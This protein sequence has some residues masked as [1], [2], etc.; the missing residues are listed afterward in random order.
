M[1]PFDLPPGATERVLF[2]AFTADSV[3]VDS[4]NGDN[5]PYDP[6]TYLANLNFDNVLANAVVADSLG[7]LVMSTL[8]PVTG[9]KVSAQTDSTVTVR[10]QRAAFQNVDGYNIYLSE[11]PPELLPYPGI[12]AP[13]LEPDELVLVALVPPTQLE[14]TFESLDPGSIYFVNVASVADGVVGNTGKTIFIRSGSTV[15]QRPLISAEYLFIQE[16]QS[17]IIEWSAPQGVTV[18]HYH[19]YRGDSAWASTKYYPFYDEGG[20]ADSITPIDSFYIADE[21]ITYYYYAMEPWVEVDALDTSFVDPAPND[22][23]VY[24]VNA[25]DEF[26]FETPFSDQMQVHFVEPRTEDIL[27]VIGR[28]LPVSGVS[29]PDLVA[30]Y[31]SLLFGYD[32]DFYFQ[33]DSI[34]YEHCPDGDPLCFDWHD[35]MRYQ[36]VLIDDGLQRT[37]LEPEYEDPVK[38]Y[39]R[40]LLSGGQLAIFGP[41]QKFLGVSRP[42]APGVYP[43]DHWFVDRFFGIDSMAYMGIGHCAG[44][45]DCHQYTGFQWAESIVGSMPDLAFNPNAPFS[46]FVEMIWPCGQC[47]PDV[48]SFK[49]NATAEVTHTAHTLF[50]TTSLLEAEPI[51]LKTEV[52]G[53]ETWLFGFHLWYMDLAPAR[54]LIEA[55]IQPQVKTTIEPDT[56]YG[57]WAHA[58][59]PQPLSV[60]LGQFPEGLSAADVAPATLIVNSTVTPSNWTIL[61]SHP[62]YVGEVLELEIPVAPFVDSYGPVWGTSARQYQVTGQFLIKCDSLS[63][64]GTVVMSGHLPGDVSADGMLDISDLIYLVDYM[65]RDGAAPRYPPAAD[66]DANCSLDIGDIIYLVDFYFADGAPPRPGCAVE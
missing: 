53:T 31:D 29:L 62:N 43:A 65:F 14:Y 30:F 18:D 63:A 47:A 37:V 15:Y 54:Q 13:W 51:G 57:Y 19:L 11:V 56:V 58:I 8:Y 20:A 3:H 1:G 50:P 23:D 5:L 64:S 6:D 24:F 41:I 4:T 55:I 26:G 17:A 45:I 33:G 44:D 10:W 16:S 61:A 21:G 9:L 49:V 28:Q 25:V 7:Q 34:N 40:Y 60:Y 59:D 2:A 27:V 36:L 32:Y 38:G 39:T 22:N 66:V 52:E 12:P 48:A 35:F 42:T 46:R